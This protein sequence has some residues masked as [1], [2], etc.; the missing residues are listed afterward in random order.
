MG[1]LKSIV[2]K[3]S[4]DIKTTPEKIWEFFLNIEQNYQK[5]H[6]EDHVTLRWI[7]GKPWEEGSIVYSEQYAHGKLHKL[8]Y[9]ITRVIP[10]REIEFCPLSRF[11]RI[12]FPKNRFIIESKGQYC[13]FTA[14]LYLKVGWLVRKLAGKKLEAGIAS[15]ER[16]IKEEGE[17]LKKILE[18]QNESEV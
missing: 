11:L 18:K 8:K 7:K 1:L 12:Y 13:S 4:I 16:H 6:P 10:K 14:E 5:W 17:N 2:L 3:H 15:A 9:V